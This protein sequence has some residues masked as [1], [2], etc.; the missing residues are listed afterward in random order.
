MLRIESRLEG[1]TNKPPI[2]NIGN[3][4]ARHTRSLGNRLRSSISKIYHG[5]T[6]TASWDG[7]L[8][9]SDDCNTSNDIT[10]VSRIGILKHPKDCDTT[11]PLRKKKKVRF[12]GNKPKPKVYS[13]QPLFQYAYDLWWTKEEIELSKVMQADF[14]DVSEDVKSAAKAYLKSFHSGYNQLNADIKDGTDFS[15]SLV[16][17]EVYRN[18]VLGK[19]HGFSGL[20]LYN[21]KSYDAKRDKSIE[22]VKSIAK[23]YNNE[24]Y[25]KYKDGNQVS[26]VIR[27][28]S[29]A[30]SVA[31]RS[32]A[33]ISAHA[34]MEACAQDED[35]LH[36]PG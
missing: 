32:W 30:L 11:T 16:S 4:G 28:K 21:V 5:P 25:V 17:P 6:R 24:V 12:N 9:N 14:S 18:L 10:C 2:A 8:F 1:D 26:E 31:D 7:T 35:V 27:Q 34:D 23:K 15:T 20:E 29:E 22:I 33:Y 3:R 13:I 19:Y 36:P